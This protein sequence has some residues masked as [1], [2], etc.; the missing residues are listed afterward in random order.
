MYKE[1][2]EDNLKVENNGWMSRSTDALEG[3]L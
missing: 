2:I 3:Y 1:I